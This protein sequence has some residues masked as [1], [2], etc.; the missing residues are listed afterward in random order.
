MVQ[1]GDKDN[2]F[3]GPLK[4]KRKKRSAEETLLGENWQN[5]VNDKRRKDFSKCLSAGNRGKVSRVTGK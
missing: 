4:I 1:K 2:P 5:L 3:Q